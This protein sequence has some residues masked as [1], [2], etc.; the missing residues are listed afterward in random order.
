MYLNTIQPSEGSRKKSKRVGRGIGCTLGK[1]CGRGHKGQKSRSGGFHKVGFEGG[2]NP[3]SLRLPKLKGFK[4]GFDPVKGL[5]ISLDTLN[6][7]KDGELVNIETLIQKGIISK[8]TKIQDIKILNNGE[9]K[10]KICIEGVSVSKSAKAKIER[11]G[12]TIK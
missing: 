9:I 8:N 7:F 1:T 3:L 12:G 6:L 10:A 4:R 2:Q 5:V 11:A